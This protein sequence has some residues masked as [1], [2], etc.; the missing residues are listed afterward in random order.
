MTTKQ[1]MTMKDEELKA[2]YAK[3][4]DEQYIEEL[5]DFLQARQQYLKNNSSSNC[6][7]MLLAFDKIYVSTKSLWTNGI[8]SEN[9]FWMLKDELQDVERK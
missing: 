5:N 3:F 2:Y 4:N 1:E 9:D 7:T 6:I 8:I